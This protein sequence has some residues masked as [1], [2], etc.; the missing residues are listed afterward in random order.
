MKLVVAAALAALCAPWGANAQTLAEVQ[1][2]GQLNC[3]APGDMPGFG[4]VDENGMRQ[5]FDVAFCRALAGAV[6][7][8][9]SAVQLDFDREPNFKGILD[10]LATGQIDVLASSIT[11]TFSRDVDLEFEFIGVNYYDGQGMM[12]PRDLGVSSVMD[13]D[14]ADICVNAGTTTEQNTEDFY[15]ANQ[16]SYQPVEMSSTDDMLDAYLGGGCD[17]ITSDRSELAAMRSS[18]DQPD[19]HV[20]L[21]ETISKEPLGPLVRHG[22][23]NWIEIVRWTLYALI[24]AEEKGI[25]QANVADVAATPATDPEVARLLGQE[26][27]LGAMLGLEPDW[28]VQA[29]SAAGNYGEIFEAHLGKG[30]PLGLPRGLNASY[31]DGGILYAPPFL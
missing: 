20:I 23:H 14:G 29:I 26:G 11:W 25:T 10:T 22:D 24:V 7:G 28:A 12:V 5:G 16:M 13:L 21:P 2:R 9:P 30:T 1:E 18:L 17:V 31:R 4:Y 6:L 15:R 19:E 27:D 8:D 3:S